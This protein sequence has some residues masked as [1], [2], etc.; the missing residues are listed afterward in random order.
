[1]SNLMPD[2]KN[3]FMRGPLIRMTV[4]NYIDGQPGILTSLSYKISNDTPW[5]IS[6]NNEELNLPHI[7]EVSLGFT[8]IGSQTRDK[9]LISEK[10]STTSHIAQNWNGGKSESEGEY[11][12]PDINKVIKNGIQA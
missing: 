11:I 8:P 2:Y 1:M 3:N 7:I 5:E 4:G 12:Y 9:N 10:S 6:L